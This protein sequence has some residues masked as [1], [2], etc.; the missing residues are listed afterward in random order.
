M[1]KKLGVVILLSLLILLLIDIPILIKGSV[2]LGLCVMFIVWISIEYKSIGKFEFLK[3]SLWF[4]T[5]IFS[6]SLIIGIV[7]YIDE[8]NFYKRTIGIDIPKYSSILTEKDTH[9]G[10]NGDGEYFSIIE[11]SDSDKDEFINDIKQNSSWYALPISA[12]KKRKIYFGD[13]EYIYGEYLGKIPRD[14]KNGAYYFRNRAAEEYPDDSM[15]MA[16]HNFDFGVMDY[17]KN[18]LYIY[19]LDT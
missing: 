17:D 14:I 11:I 7:K 9:G 12:E 18:I 5:F 10:F 4:F 13:K 8:K 2:G 1:S 6:F 3:T 15:N 19:V 16:A